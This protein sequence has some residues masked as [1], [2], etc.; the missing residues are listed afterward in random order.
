MKKREKEMEKKAGEKERTYKS[1]HL[2]SSSEIY[3]IVLEL[4]SGRIPISDLM[5]IPSLVG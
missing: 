2:L 5:Y 3:L 1:I 4:V